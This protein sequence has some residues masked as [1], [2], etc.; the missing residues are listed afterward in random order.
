MRDGERNGRTGADHDIL[1]DEARDVDGEVLAGLRLVG[2]ELDVG[3][4]NSQIGLACVDVQ[5]S[6]SAEK[7]RARDAL[8]QSFQAHLVCSE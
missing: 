2:G 4:L 3:D 8:A 5:V 1:E 6:M 7:V